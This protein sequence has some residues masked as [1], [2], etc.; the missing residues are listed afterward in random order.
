MQLGH[1]FNF[2]KFLF[3]SLAEIACCA[4]VSEEII[5]CSITVISD[6]LH[7]RQVAIC[8]EAI[9]IPANSKRHS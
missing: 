7:D 1:I 5:N 2:C 9:A 3:N 8:G 4:G 6:L